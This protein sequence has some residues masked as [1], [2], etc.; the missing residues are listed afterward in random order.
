MRICV[1]KT[2]PRLFFIF[3]V[4]TRLFFFVLW[5]VQIYILS[6]GRNELLTKL[7]IVFIISNNLDND[8]ETNIPLPYLFINPCNTQFQSSLANL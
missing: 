5:L 4:I 1:L 3:P 2:V 7:I 6:S 8:C